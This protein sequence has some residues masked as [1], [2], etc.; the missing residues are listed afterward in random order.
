MVQGYGLSSVKRKMRISAYFSRWLE[1]K[2]VSLRHVSFEQAVRFLRYRGPKTRRGDAAALEELIVFV[3][4]LGAI[5][6]EKISA[7]RLTSPERCVRAYERY[8]REV[9]ALT[10][11]TILHYVPFVKAFLKDRFGAA[12]VA[13]SRL[14]AVDVVR[15]VQ[16][17]AP[18]LHPRQAKHLTTVLRSFLRYGRYCGD[19]HLDL[20]AA[21]PLVPNW[22]MTSIPR[23]I[24]ADQVRKLL[25][26]I[27]RRTP[28]G[29][30][31]YAILLLLARLGVRSNEVVLLELDN[32]DW[33]AGHLSVLLKAA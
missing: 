27:D 4:S 18:R 7:P 32:I 10:P 19:V 25:A 9:R 3:R 20:A 12:R 29:R 21:V 6:V 11:V 22:S 24:A 15:F 14:R 31:D 30:R 26:Q 1:L 33:D 5:P 8:L 16:R 13:L 17:Q 2:K 28:V 23:G